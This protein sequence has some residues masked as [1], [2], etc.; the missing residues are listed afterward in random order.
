MQAR[1][2]YSEQTSFQSTCRIR[3]YKGSPWHQNDKAMYQNVERW[4][5][6]WQQ[7]SN[8]LVTCVLQWRANAGSEH[9]SVQNTRRFRAYAGSKH[10]PVQSI[11]R[12]RAYA[13]SE[14]H[15]LWAYAGSEHTPVQRPIGSEHTPVQRPIGSEHMPVQRPID[16]EQMPV[17]G[18][19]S[20][21]F[22]LRA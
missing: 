22:S 1:T 19:I 7:V 8:F 11:R 9:T 14:T 21:D 6:K 18:P 16:S 13:S 3:A 15:R 2:S 5:K 12:F 10:T 4:H 17:Q 20:S